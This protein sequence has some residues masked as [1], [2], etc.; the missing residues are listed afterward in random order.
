MFQVGGQLAKGENAKKLSSFESIVMKKKK[1]KE[2]NQRRRSLNVSSM[3]APS[4]KPLRPANSINNLNR[5]TT[6]GLN[7]TISAPTGQPRPRKPSTGIAT[8]P[9]WCHETLPRYHEDPVMAI[10]AL[11]KTVGLGAD[12]K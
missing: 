3:P 5:T 12:K 2:E 4:R 1:L 11:N 7:S 10:Q 9:P 8:G 6:M